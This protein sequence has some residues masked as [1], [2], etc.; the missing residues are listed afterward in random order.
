MRRLFV[1]HRLL[2]W[3]CTDLFDVVS[4]VKEY[5]HFLPLCQGSEIIERKGD[6]IK[7]RLEIGFPP[8]TASYTSH[9][10]LERPLKVKAVCF[11]G[12]LFSHLICSWNFTSKTKRTTLVQ[13]DLD[14]EL[15][16]PVLDSLFHHKFEDVSQ[17]T[18][19][20]FIR[21]TES[22][23]GPPIPCNTLDILS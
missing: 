20:A 12:D 10:T 16:N 7:A 15:K 19:Q 1:C 14:L 2:G 4:N 8:M 23:Y 3:S 17:A 13:L 18:M 5:K 6:N 21:R 9:V 22:I 11:E